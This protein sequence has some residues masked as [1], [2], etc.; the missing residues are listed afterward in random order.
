MQCSKG[1]MDS[2]PTSGEVLENWQ[3]PGHAKEVRNWISLCSWENNIIITII[4]ITTI[5]TIIMITWETIIVRLPNHGFVS[6][7][8]L[9]R[10]S[11][12][13]DSSSNL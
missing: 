9:C 1:E 5:T 4:T 6:P 3:L 2:V 8:V 12:A 7:P 10:R 13:F 11:T